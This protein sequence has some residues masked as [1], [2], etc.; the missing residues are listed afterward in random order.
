MP[1]VSMTPSN[2]PPTGVTRASQVPA[3]DAPSGV[4]RASQAGSATPPT[5]V[6]LASLAGDNTPPT[7]VTRTSQTPS[8]TPP[9][10]VAGAVQVPGNDAPATVTGG[11]FTPD[12]GAP[13]AR[14]LSRTRPTDT[15]P[16]PIGY[17]PTIPAPT[18]ESMHTPA[19]IQTGKLVADVIFGFY[20]TKAAEVILGVQLA[21]QDLPTGADVIITLV[22]AEGTTLART[23]TL[24]AGES[25]KDVPFETPLALLA[26]AIVRAKVTQVGSTKPGSYLTANLI[27]QRT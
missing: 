5:A 13:S 4:T 15:V 18:D 11:S 1:T 2:T 10:G 22:D 6:A 27:V 25:Y 26:G 3:N 8:A 7:G 23:A 9:S 14:T 21:I 12:N 17:A 16:S 19:L 24:P 20:K